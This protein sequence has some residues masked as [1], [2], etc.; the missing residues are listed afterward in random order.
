V[1]RTMLSR[2]TNISD[3]EK[4]FAPKHCVVEFRSSQKAIDLCWTVEDDVLAVK[5][6]Q[7][8]RCRPDFVRLHDFPTN[9]L[10]LSLLIHIMRRC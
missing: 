2:E 9:R 5:L 7:Q 10:L 4:C 6:Q 3:R 1:N 8:K